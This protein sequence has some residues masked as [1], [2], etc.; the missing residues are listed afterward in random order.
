MTLQASG[1]ISMDDIRYEIYVDHSTGN[2]V[3]NDQ[4][5]RTLAGVP[6]GAISLSDFYGKTWGAKRRPSSATKISSGGVVTDMSNA[7]D[8]SEATYAKHRANSAAGARAVACNVRYDWGSS[9]LW[10]GKLRILREFVILEEYDFQED[11]YTGGAMSISYSVDGGQNYTS[12]EDIGQAAPLGWIEVDITTPV[13]GYNLKVLA[14]NVAASTANLG[15]SSAL[16][17]YDITFVTKGVA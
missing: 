14:M 6:N 3:L 12:I 13:A 16:N 11:A 1:P 8:T 7:Y 17:I 9:W 10:A 4:T 5:C 15:G 2:I